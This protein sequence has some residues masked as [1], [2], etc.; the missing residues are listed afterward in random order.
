M[1]I[2]RR[3]GLS[4]QIGIFEWLGGVSRL[5]FFIWR[6]YWTYGLVQYKC[7]E[8]VTK[9]AVTNDEEMVGMSNA[10]Y[11]ALLEVI[12]RLIEAKAASVEEAARIVREAKTK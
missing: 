5:A 7:R 4:N 9:M 12:A 2:Q 1:D 11:D 10:Q 6:V 3:S 8:E